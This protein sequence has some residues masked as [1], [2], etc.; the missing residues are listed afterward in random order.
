MKKPTS[1]YFNNSHSKK[2]LGNCIFL[3]D[4]LFL[5]HSCLTVFSFSQFPVLFPILQ[6]KG[7]LLLL[8]K[9]KLPFPY[10]LELSGNYKLCKTKIAA[11]IIVQTSRISL[12]L[13]NPVFESSETKL[14][15]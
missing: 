13:V 9:P 14:K 10:L 7:S 1:H 5:F 6:V 4:F 15:V 12:K 3:L 2:S 11:V 8:A